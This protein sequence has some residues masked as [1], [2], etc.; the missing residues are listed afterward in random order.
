MDA[1]VVEEYGTPR[2]RQFDEPVAGA[3]ET[4]VEVGAAGVNPV[5][6]AKA[7]GTFYAGRA[8]VPFVAGGEGVGTVADGRRVYFDAP[9]HPFGSMAQRALVR[10]EELIEVAPGCD[11]ALAVALGVAGLAAWLPLA[12]RADLQPG[13]TVLVLGATGVLGHVAVQ[14]AKLLGAGRV[15]AAGRD[16]EALARVEEL[17]ADAVV[18]FDSADA[19]DLTNAFRGAADGDVDVVI[20]PLWGAPGVAALAALGTGGRHIQIGQSAG[21]TATVP[22]ANIRGKLV[23]IRG[24]TNFLAPHEVKAAAHRTMTKHAAAGRLTVDVDRV[25]LRD[26]G[27]AWERMRSGTHGRKLVL[28]P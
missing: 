2:W 25:P 23:D 9:V 3:G 14:A 6:L 4:V 10:S 16:P 17:G 22:S 11:D 27:K 28:V 21:A 19:D 13:E 7:A 26:V 20:D 15:V 18:R 12:W 1:A 8:R 24:F 5:D